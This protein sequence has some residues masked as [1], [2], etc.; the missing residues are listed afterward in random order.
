M[1]KRLGNNKKKNYKKEKKKVLRIVIWYNL[2]SERGSGE[3]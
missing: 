3:Y 2:K 1:I